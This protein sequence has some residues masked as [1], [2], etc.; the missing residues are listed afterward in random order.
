MTLD[1]APEI[2]GLKISEQWTARRMRVP[3]SGI[4]DPNL[5]LLPKFDHLRPVA[6]TRCHHMKSWS[7]GSGTACARRFESRVC[8][9]AA[10]DLGREG[11]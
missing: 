1:N 7:S 11:S 3:F 5:V 2:K 10:E 8:G 4:G 6:Q 9:V